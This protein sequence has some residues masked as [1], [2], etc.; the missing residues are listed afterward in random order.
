[1]S[2]RSPSRVGDV[3]AVGVLYHVPAGAHP[4]FAPVQVL[5]RILTSGPSS[6]LG[7]ALVGAKKASSVEGRVHALHDPG[8]L[9]IMAKVDRPGS[10]DD[11]RDV[12]VNAIERVREEGVTQEE[13]ARGEQILSA[14]RDLMA[15]DPDPNRFVIELSD[16]GRRRETGGSFSFT[17]TGSN[18]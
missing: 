8:T 17:A 9:L 12:M 11:V 6:R 7:K 16:T 1:M 2:G 5:S 14:G 4:D 13:V 15:T 3:G 18:K 10:Q